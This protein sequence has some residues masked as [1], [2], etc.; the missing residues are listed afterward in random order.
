MVARIAIFAG[1]SAPLTS[2]EGSASA[3]PR[4]CASASAS[5]YA[6]PP[7]IS[8]RM[9]FV[10]PFTIP[11]TRWTFVATSASRSTLITGMAA[12][13]LASKRSCTPARE[14]AEKSSAPRRAMSCLLAETTGF[15]ASR[16]AR[17]W[18]PAG[19]RPPITSATTAIDGSSRIAAKSLVSTPGGAVPVR[20]LS[21][22]RTRARTTRSLS[23]VERS[24]SAAFS[25]RSRS[26]AE[27]TVPYPR[28]ATG[29]STVLIRPARRY[30]AALLDADEEGEARAGAVRRRVDDDAP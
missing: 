1:A 24:M 29:T 13:T 17:T 23:P 28:R 30:W 9:K 21:G 2:S 20:S 16:R 25:L 26:T 3:N 5:S 19:S 7:S 27:P 10:V 15:P 14:A 6:A 8:V 18:S 12:Q 11:R 4:R 22:S